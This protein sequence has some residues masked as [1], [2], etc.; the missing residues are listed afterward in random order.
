M[1]R[2]RL[3]RHIGFIPT[4]LR[5]VEAADR[6]CGKHLKAL[7]PMLVADALAGLRRAATR[8]SRISA[9]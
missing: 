2:S 8:A 4:C 6:V 7:I 1:S 9:V 5:G 3:P